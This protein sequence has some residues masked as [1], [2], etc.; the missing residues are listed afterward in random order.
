MV[1]D[2]G[3]ELADLVRVEFKGVTD[4]AH[5]TRVRPGGASRLDIRQRATLDPSS[6]Q[7]N[8]TLLTQEPPPSPLSQGAYLG[9]HG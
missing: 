9:F 1:P 8:Q 6:G 4:H 5:G 3:A 2:R 7:G